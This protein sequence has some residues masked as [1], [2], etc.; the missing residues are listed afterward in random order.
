MEGTAHLPNPGYMKEKFK[1]VIETLHAPDMGLQEN[2]P[3]YMKENFVIC[4]ESLHVPDTGKQE[5]VSGSGA[6]LSI[7]PA[8]HWRIACC[9]FVCAS[10]TFPSVLC[11]PFS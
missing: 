1:L 8:L 5:N 6:R 10:D 4:I 2:N 9:C 11:F 7:F 3:G